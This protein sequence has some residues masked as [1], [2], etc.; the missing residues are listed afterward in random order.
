MN[1][2]EIL[3]YFLS[4]F[5]KKYH[6]VLPSFP[7]VL[8][9]DPTLMFVNSGMTPL[10]EFFIGKK[11]NIFNR[12]VSVQKCLRVSGKHNDLEDV[13]KDFYH[14]TMFE[15]LGNWSFGCCVKKQAITWAWKLLTTI[16]QIPIDKIYVTIFS[17]ETKEGIYIDE[18]THS[19]WEK[20]IFNKKIITC[21]K[22]H[23]FWEMS[24]KGPCGPCSE[25]HV[26]LRSNHKK[27]NKSGKKLIN[28]EHPQVI[29]IWNIVFMEFFRSFDG[30][31]EKLSE[32]HID[33]GLGFERLCR[34]LQKKNS[35]YDTDIFSFLI[36]KVEEISHIVY[37]INIFTDISIRVVIDHI[38]SILFSIAD[39][40]NPSGSGAGYVIR[41]LIRRSLSYGYRFLKN[42]AFI[43]QLIEPI[44]TEM[45]SHHPELFLYKAGIEEKIF[46]EEIYFLN[47]LNKGMKRLETIIK[48]TKDK[49]QK[50]ITGIMIFELYNTYGFPMDLSRLLATENALVI[51]EIG[52]EKELNIQKSRSRLLRNFQ[53]DDWIFIKEINEYFIIYN[54]LSINTKL[55]KIKRIKK[56]S[57][58]ITI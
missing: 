28:K 54:K 58:Y 36:R 52:F 45:D 14:H 32:R 11:K 17:G 26:D 12:K 2:K 3:Y 53:I 16:Y 46:Y 6:H 56:I 47:T 20:I 49:K 13:G 33:T 10:K 19:Y 23:N 34:V 29:E 5:H 48:S 15:M 57:L 1:Y 31:I 41:R 44:M 21:V 7:I 18:E 27:K 39:G 43:Y 38:R 35:N 24:D 51:D 4:F 50:S 9:T 25:I 40:Q 30:S 8:K 22:K 55:S 42:E 37:G